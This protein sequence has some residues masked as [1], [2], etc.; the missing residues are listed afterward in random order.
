[1]RTTLTVTAIAVSSDT[2]SDLPE[3]TG[4]H[5]RH[6]SCMDTAAKYTLKDLFFEA[7]AIEWRVL[8]ALGQAIAG[9]AVFVAVQ[10]VNVVTYPAALVID[11][12]SLFLG[13]E[14]RTV[15]GVSAADDIS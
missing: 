15:V 12:L 14:M 8:H 13:F 5:S 2:S 1:M 10:L 11:L 7:L 6:T 9:S 3:R 4:I